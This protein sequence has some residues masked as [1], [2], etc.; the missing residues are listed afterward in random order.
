METAVGLDSYNI[1]P[2]YEGV[3]LIGKKREISD[4]FTIIGRYREIICLIYRIIMMKLHH[5]KVKM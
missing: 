4:V 3:N 5:D 1:A 2:G